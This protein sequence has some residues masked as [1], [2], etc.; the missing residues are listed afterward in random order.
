M[1]EASPAKVQSKFASCQSGFE[2]QLHCCASVKKYEERLAYDGGAANNGRPGD[3][4]AFA[5]KN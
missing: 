3:I 5:G 4:S 1:T 2:Q